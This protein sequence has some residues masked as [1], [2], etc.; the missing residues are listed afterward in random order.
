MS[1]QG[2]RTP[3]SLVT[4]RRGPPGT[5]LLPGA[6]CVSRP[7]VPSAPRPPQFP[8]CLCVSVSF[9]RGC[10]LSLLGSFPLLRRPR[11]RARACG[12]V[13]VCA[14]ARVS[15]SS[16]RAPGHRHPPRPRQAHGKGAR[17]PDP[18]VRRDTAEPPR[19]LEQPEVGRSS[20]LRP[21][22]PAPSP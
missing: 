4:R 2:L 14:R 16:D 5:R 3:G 8:G 15:A 21:A 9:T 7:G 17:S 1:P 22:P 12:R 18:G 20:L 19:V 10:S 6:R 13:G 11:E